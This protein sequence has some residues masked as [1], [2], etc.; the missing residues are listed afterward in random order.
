MVTCVQKLVFSSVGAAFI[1][2][3]RK[4]ILAR[5]RCNNVGILSAIWRK[6]RLAGV[7]S[8]ITRDAHNVGELGQFPMHF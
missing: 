8:D 5:G 6:G 7:A 2:L 4:S 3:A 1:G